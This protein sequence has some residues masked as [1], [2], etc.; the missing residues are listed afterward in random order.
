MTNDMTQAA[1]I[2]GQALAMESA[3]ETLLQEIAAYVEINPYKVYADYQV[4]DEQAAMLLAGDFESFWDSIALWEDNAW[5][6]ADW[7]E[8]ESMALSEFGERIA[9]LWPED[10]LEDDSDWDDMPQEVQEALDENKSVDCS[11]MIESAIRAY[12]GMIVCTLYQFDELSDDAKERARDWYRSCIETDELSNLD[13]W[14]SIA[15]IL[16]ID[17]ATRSVPLMSGATRQDPRIWWN[18]FC[19]QGDGASWEG[20]YSYAKGA[21]RAIRQYAPQDTVLHSIAD[22]LQSAQRR[23]F[24][25][26]QATVTQSGHYYH[27]GTMR[28]DVTRTDDID[29]SESDCDTVSEALRDFADWIYSQLRAQWEYLHSDESVDEHIRINEYEFTESGEVA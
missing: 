9:A 7:S 5:S 8:L 25:R 13:D 23:N 29:V 17:F 1:L 22:R 19:S 15:A 26:L 16:G 4:T 6:Y 18:G 2:A 21:A 14:L 12:D 27:S 11:D 24:Y 3:R 20:W 28:F 10:E